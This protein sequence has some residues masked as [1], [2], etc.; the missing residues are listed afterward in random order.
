MGFEGIADGPME[1]C[2]A[3]WS[4]GRATAGEDVGVLVGVDVG[5]VDAGALELL[6]L[7][8]GFALD[9]VV[10]DVA[11]RRAEAKSTSWAKGFAVGAEEGGD[12][13]GVELRGLRR[14]G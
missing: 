10:A 4:S 14:R 12:A 13:L 11:G 8:E 3:R 6:D 9:V 2:S 7:G 1:V 5:D